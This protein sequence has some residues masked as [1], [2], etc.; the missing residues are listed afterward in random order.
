MD[1][2]LV[3][4]VLWVRVTSIPFGHP[5]HADRE[6]HVQE[7]GVIPHL[8]HFIPMQEHSLD[9]DYRLRVDHRWWLE[10][11]LVCVV[12]EMPENNRAFAVLHGVENFGTQGGQV[13]TV[14]EE[15]FWR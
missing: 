1:I 15:S 7:H 6:C 3:A 10:H 11:R 2:T 8:V 12:I 14:E 4:G 5:P 9:N 13:N